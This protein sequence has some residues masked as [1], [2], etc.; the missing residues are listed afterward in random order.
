MWSQPRGKRLSYLWKN[1]RIVLRMIERRDVYQRDDHALRSD[2]LS[3]TNRRAAA[4][5]NPAPYAGDVFLVLPSSIPRPAHS[6]PRLAWRGFVQGET[7][8][9]RLPGNDSGA[10]LRP[11]HVQLL[12][13]VLSSRIAPGAAR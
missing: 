8:V 1:A 7:T 12:A 4:R 2:R 11:P 3:A 6:D 5:Y 9:V 10:L 13:E